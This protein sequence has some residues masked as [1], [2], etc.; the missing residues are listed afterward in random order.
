[1]EVTTDPSGGAVSTYRYSAYGQTEAKGSTGV[2]APTVSDPAA[3]VQNPWRFNSKRWDAGSGSYDMGFRT[4]SPL[5]TRYSSRD[6]YNGAL[7][8]MRLGLVPWNTNRYAFAGGNPVT[9]IELD[10]P[11]RTWV[12]DRQ[13]P[14]VRTV[15]PNASTWPRISPPTIPTV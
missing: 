9:G 6:M 10:G 3:T 13:V 11:L 8:D 1:M 4:Y 15:T 12:E 7:A 14:S 5:S 2:D